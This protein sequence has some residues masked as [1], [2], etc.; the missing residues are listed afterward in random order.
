M[1]SAPHA[2]NSL[3]L[4][5]DEPLVATVLADA[6]EESGYHVSLC[7]TGF[8]A[9][10]YL[11]MEDSIAAVV[12]DIGLGEGPDGWEVARRAREQFPDAP[13]IY[14]TGRGAGAAA[15]Q[16]VSESLILQKPFASKDLLLA[17]SRL[18]N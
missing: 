5:E 1:E 14:I 15:G 6:L 3:L 13:V 16:R 12:T 9:L 17:L 18:L 10:N 11:E 7:G 2:S 8:D 4:V